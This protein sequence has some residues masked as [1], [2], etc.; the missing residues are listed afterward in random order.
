[1]PLASAGGRGRK[2]VRIAFE[3]GAGIERFGGGA[4]EIG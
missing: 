2:V 4:G 1:M 3:S